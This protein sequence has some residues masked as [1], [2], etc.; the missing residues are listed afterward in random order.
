MT[1]IPKSTIIYYFLVLTNE[2]R[3]E[4]RSLLTN[5]HLM[6]ANALSPQTNQCWLGKMPNSHVKL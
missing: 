1:L 3:Y 5:G 6:V 4:N 2:Q